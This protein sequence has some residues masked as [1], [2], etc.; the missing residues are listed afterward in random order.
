MKSRLALCAA[1][2]L[3]GCASRPERFEPRFQARTPAEAAVIA[4]CR[5]ALAGLGRENGPTLGRRTAEGAVTASKV[6]VGERVTEQNAG[7][8][9]LTAPLALAA[10]AAAAVVGSGVD[11]AQRRAALERAFADCVRR[12]APG[13]E[14]KASQPEAA[15]GTSAPPAR[16]GAAELRAL[17]VEAPK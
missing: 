13:P 12:E 7:W 10:G 1:L 9:V 17:G 2:A 11:K 16:D 8:Y 14:A 3:A 4:G 15:Q 5:R 6:I